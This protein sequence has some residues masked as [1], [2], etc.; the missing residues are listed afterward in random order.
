MKK[1]IV[2]LDDDEKQCRHLCDMLERGHY[3]ATPMHSL[4]NL[5]RHLQ[6]SDCLVAIVDI[7]APSVNNRVIRELTMKNPGA[8][9]LGVTKYRFNPE[10]KESIH[11][12][13][14][15]CLTKQVDPDELLYWLRSIFEDDP[16][17]KVKWWTEHCLHPKWIIPKSPDL[18]NDEQSWMDTMVKVT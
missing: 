13:I 14:Y 15:A 10:F 1:E 18:I 6:E 2:V 7:N 8:S 11:H 12:H 3:R 16:D 9:F 4:P 17:L 5:E